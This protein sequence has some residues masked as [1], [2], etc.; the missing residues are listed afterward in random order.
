MPDLS[1]NP[2]Y[3]SARAAIVAPER[4]IPTSIYSVQ[5]W[6]P[7]LGP[8][9][10]CLIMLLRALCVDAPRRPDG[11]KQI[12]CSLQELGE[13]LNLDK[14]TLHRWFE[15]EPIPNDDPW[16]KIVPTDDKTKYLTLFI[17]R[18][19]YAYETHR[20]KAKRIGLVL[21]IL[22]EDPVVPEDEIKL[23][24]HLE[25]LQLQQGEMPLN[26]YVSYE[27]NFADEVNYL[28]DSPPVTVDFDYVNGQNVTLQE[29]VK[30][31][32]VTLQESVKRQNVTLQESV[33]GQ[34]VTLQESVKGQNVTLQESVK[35]QNVTLESVKGQNVTSEKSVKGQNVTSE[36]SVKGQNVTSQESVKGQNV[37]LQESVKGQNVTL[38]E[39][40]KGQNVT[41]DGNLEGVKGQNVTLQGS[42][43]GQNVTSE[44]FISDSVNVNVNMLFLFFKR[45]KDS[46][47][48]VNVAGSKIFEPIVNL[49]EELLQD[50]HSTGMLYKSLQALYPENWEIYVKA[51]HAALEAATADSRV[52][53]GAVFVRTLRDLAQMAEVD[54]GLKSSG[55]RAPMPTPPQPIVSQ[56]QL[57]MPLLLKTETIS[58]NAAL[59]VEAQ[60]VLHQQMTQATYTS[61][62]RGTTFVERQGNLFVIG[63]KNKMALEWLENRLA[64]TVQ[65]VLSSVVGQAVSIEFKLLDGGGA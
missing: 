3:L 2:V 14:R 22:M 43:K 55:E 5:K 32:N 18:L 48:N 31:Q 62:I 10:W 23:K 39:D 4:A 35:G 53:K 13:A 58:G 63:V 20:G 21:E 17:P 46:N 37:T 50:S 33:K 60:A 28:V 51:V 40:V 19:R 29:N 25:M 57:P 34:N 11:T 44:N 61:V 8:E 52:K 54:L 41:S 15:H 65:R 45:L 47:V 59:W 38:Q 24:R 56:E 42:V 9:R 12:I 16:R 49:T 7:R 27:S 1:L 30:R 26:G 6:L 36:K 64:N